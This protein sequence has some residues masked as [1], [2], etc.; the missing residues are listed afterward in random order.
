MSKGG[1]VPHDKMNIPHMSDKKFN[2]IEN[3]NSHKNDTKH[4]N[5]HTHGLKGKSSTRSPNHK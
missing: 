1:K 3:A 2:P 5:L 4:N